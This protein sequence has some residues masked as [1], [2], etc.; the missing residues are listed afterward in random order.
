MQPSIFTC[1]STFP[2]KPFNY[3]PIFCTNHTLVL[4]NC[5]IIQTH[6]SG[7]QTYITKILQLF[8]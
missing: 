8:L 2:F 5:F 4:L 7:F 6:T 1:L 3:E